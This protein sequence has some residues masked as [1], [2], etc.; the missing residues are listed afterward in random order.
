M[1]YIAYGKNAHMICETCNQANVEAVNNDRDNVYT[2]FGLH[3]ET[4][5]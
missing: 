2:L 3:K 5:L 4:R 1:T